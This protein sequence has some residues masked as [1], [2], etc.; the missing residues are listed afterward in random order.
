MK[1]LIRSS[2][3][4][5]GGSVQRDA[6]KGTLPHKHQIYGNQEVVSGC[7]TMFICNHQAVGH[8]ELRMRLE[9]TN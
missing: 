2:V 4:L 6:R 3:E 9:V 8:Q 7:Q 5:V 1:N